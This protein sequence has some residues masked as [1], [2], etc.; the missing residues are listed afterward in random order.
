VG[1]AVANFLT[2]DATHQGAYGTHTYYKGAAMIHNLRTYL[3]DSLFARAQTAVLQDFAFTAV[4]AAQYRDHLT[5]VSGVDMGPFFEDWIF[6]PGFSNFEIEAMQVNPVGAA[7][8]VALTIQQK[9][10]GTDR[11]HTQE[12]LSV[13]FFR[14]D[15]TEQT[16]YLMASG[17]FSTATF[18]LPFEPAMVILNHDQELNLARVNEQLKVTAAGN[19]N[20]ADVDFFT[21]TAQ[22][23]PDSA[24]LHIVH[25]WTAPDPAADP[26]NVQMSDTHYWSVRGILPDGFSMRSIIRYYGGVDNLDYELAQAGIETVRMMYRP[27]V[28][29]EWEEYPYSVINSFGNGGLVRLDP[30]LPGDYALANVFLNVA[31]HNPLEDASVVLSPNPAQDVVRLQLNFPAVTADYQVQLYDLQGQLLRQQTYPKTAELNVEWSTA[32]LPNGLYIVEI[33]SGTGHRAIEL[34]VQR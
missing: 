7:F 15:W 32:D 22:T 24:L 30:L 5:Q 33:T 2:V 28:D 11:L 17:E 26:L 29:T 3:G 27:T 31:T 6:S 16:E 4:D 34:V 13:T 9:L 12:P 21:L 10:R 20:A 8:E 25:H 18:T 1:V 23:V 19:L 14:A